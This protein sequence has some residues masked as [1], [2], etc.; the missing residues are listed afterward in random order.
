[1]L[2]RESQKTGRS[3]PVSAVSSV[4]GTSDA[5]SLPTYRRLEACSIQLS[6]EQSSW[7][8]NE[9]VGERDRMACDAL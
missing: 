1:M 4:P 2:V 8:L 7:T 9:A 5:P 3:P 6:L